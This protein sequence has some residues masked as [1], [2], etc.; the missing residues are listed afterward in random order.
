M[1]WETLAGIDVRRK[2]ALLL[3][4]H[5]TA[6]A[7]KLTCLSPELLLRAGAIEAAQRLAGSFGRS[8]VRFTVGMPQKKPEQR[9]PREWILDALAQWQA[10][11]SDPLH[12]ELEKRLLAYGIRNAIIV[13]DDGDVAIYPTP[14]GEER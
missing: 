10:K 2:T 7:G 3:H 12:N 5:V 4:N 6:T 14:K 1:S 11:Y 8:D 9:E 13:E